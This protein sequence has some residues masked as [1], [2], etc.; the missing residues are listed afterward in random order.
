L[1]SKVSNYCSFNLEMKTLNIVMEAALNLLICAQIELK[2]LNQLI[3]YNL[4]CQL[5]RA[6]VLSR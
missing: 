3:K 5:V 6:D 2:E 4:S 1:Y